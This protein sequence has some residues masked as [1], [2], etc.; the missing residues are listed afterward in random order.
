MNWEKYKLISW[1]SLGN[2]KRLKFL[3]VDTQSHYT[4]HIDEPFNWRL[5][6]RANCLPLMRFVLR[7]EASMKRE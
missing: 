1:F 2:R 4:S 7:T 6:D 5:D 3:Y